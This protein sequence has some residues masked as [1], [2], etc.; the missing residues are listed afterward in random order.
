MRHLLCHEL[1]AVGF[2]GFPSVGGKGEV[3][4]NVGHGGH[5]QCHVLGEA[6]QF[7]PTGDGLPE[8]RHLAVGVGGMT[9]AAFVVAVG[10]DDARGVVDGG[11]EAALR[12]VVN[13]AAFASGAD[14]GGEMT[15][16]PVAVEG[17]DAD[18]VDRVGVP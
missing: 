8:E 15:Y 10:E 18:G 7:V 14:E 1:A 6:Q 5:A 17:V 9:L 13:K 4:A 2:H 12:P 16:R 11:E 3:P